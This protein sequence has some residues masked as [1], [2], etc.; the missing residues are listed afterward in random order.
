MGEFRG[1]DT[2]REMAK[3]SEIAI[4]NGD[5]VRTDIA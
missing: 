4:Q 3:A 1:L 2:F 5:G